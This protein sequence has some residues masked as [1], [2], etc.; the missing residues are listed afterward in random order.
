LI[1]KLLEVDIGNVSANEHAVYP[2]E[3]LA[4]EVL[5]VFVGLYLLDGL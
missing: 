2:V 1:N 5:A 4:P 3:N